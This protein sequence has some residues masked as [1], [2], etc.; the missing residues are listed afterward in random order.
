MTSDAAV[1]AA[2][3]DRARQLRLEQPAASDALE[4]FV[5]RLV[6]TGVPEDDAVRRGLEAL[7]R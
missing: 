4:R 7:S 3:E 5:A 2:L 6:A 1:P